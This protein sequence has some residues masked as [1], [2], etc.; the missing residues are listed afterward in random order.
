MECV[1]TDKP[2]NPRKAGTTRCMVYIRGASCVNVSRF[3]ESDTVCFDVL[4]YHPIGEPDV[5]NERMTHLLK[6]DTFLT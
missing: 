2:W 5:T 6:L 1:V 3:V 4:I